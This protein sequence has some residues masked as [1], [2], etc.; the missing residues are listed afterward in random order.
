MLSRTNQWVEKRSQSSQIQSK[1]LSNLSM[2][3]FEFDI[4]IAIEHVSKH[5]ID[6]CRTTKSLHSNY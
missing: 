5:K 3:C 1:V 4:S 6:F 2:Q